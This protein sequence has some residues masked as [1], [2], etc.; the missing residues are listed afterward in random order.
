MLVEVLGL[1]PHEIVKLK[2]E[3]V[4]AVLLQLLDVVALNFVYWPFV[5]LVYSLSLLLIQYVN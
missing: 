1:R 2:T 3:N 5:S 4:M